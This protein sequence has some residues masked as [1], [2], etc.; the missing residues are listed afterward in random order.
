MSLQDCK[1]KT[2]DT[3]THLLEWP[4]SK[5]LTSNPDEDVEQQ[6]HSS[7][8]SGDVKAVQSL[9]KTLQ[10]VFFFVVFYTAKHALT[11]SNCWA[12][13]KKR[14]KNDFPVSQRNMTSL[15]VSK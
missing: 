9:C 7:I 15:L 11:W 13:K 6:E 10:E 1:L 8:A 14:D 12:T 2:Q 5:K 4:K 3:T